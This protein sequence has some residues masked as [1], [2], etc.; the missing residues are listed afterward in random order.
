MHRE[1]IAKG[2]GAS[3][4]SEANALTWTVVVAYVCEYTKKH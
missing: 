1:V 3:V 2:Y 4:S